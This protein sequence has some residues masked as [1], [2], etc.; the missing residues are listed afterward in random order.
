MTREQSYDTSST[1]RLA[2]SFLPATCV[3]EMTYRCNHKCL[4]CSCPWE[5]ENNGFK[6]HKELSPEEWKSVISKLSGMGIMN[7][8]FSGGEPLLKE[9]ITDIIRFASAC[10]S[11]HIETINGELVSEFKPFKL[12]LLSN[13]LLMSHEIINLCKELNIHLSMSLPGFDTFEQHTKKDNSN[14]ILYWFG[15]AKKAGLST[16]VNITVTRKNIHE[17]YETLA[18][19]LIAGADTLLMNRFLPGGRGIKYANELMLSKEQ[20]VEMLDIAEDVLRKANRTGSVGTELPKCIIDKNKEYK[21]LTIGTRCSAGLDFF[22]I[23]PSGH[24]R[25]CNHSPVELCHFSEIENLKNHP[26][27]KTFVMKDYKPAMCKDCELLYDCDGGCREA[28]HIVSG[29][30]CSPDPLFLEK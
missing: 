27:W 21:K 23:G 7:I 29:D 14:K 16:T 25:A 20:V 15:E 11:E 9:N 24:V 5:A 17:L 4:F 30:V 3:F 13:G 26:Y 12:Y 8:A 6:K 28:A 2:P 19:A 22:V 10:K 18:E 1:S